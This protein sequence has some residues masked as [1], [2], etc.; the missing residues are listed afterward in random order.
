MKKSIFIILLIFVL[1]FSCL[2]VLQHQEYYN[3]S[4]S[5][6][7]GFDSDYGDYDSGGSWD[8]GGGSW[9][10][11]SSWDDNDDYDYRSSSRSDGNYSG[12]SGDVTLIF[13]ALGVIVFTVAVVNLIHFT[14]LRANNNIKRKKNLNLHIKDTLFYNYNLNIGDGKDVKIVQSAYASY[15]EIQ[16]A[17]MNRN[18]SP[19][20]HLLTDEMYNMYQMQ[21][22]TL[23]ADNQINVMSD[24]EFVCGGLSHIESN[25]NIETLTLTLCVNCKDY[26]KDAKTN[27]VLSGDKHAKITYIYELTFIRDVS[28]DKNKPMNCPTC[29]AQVPRQMSAVCP[30]CKNILLL[31]SSELTMSNKVI[32]HQFKH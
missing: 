27:K 4:A 22:E 9:G 21:V 10:G 30:Y 12:G 29:G 24:F 7:S 15:V 16:K 31:T 8:G 26:I 13:I 5:A 17:W 2:T 28:I 14:S 20:R 1:S 32:K 11:G 18:L 6:D 3:L 25:N 23:I 19:V